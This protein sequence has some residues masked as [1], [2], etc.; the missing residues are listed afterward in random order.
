MNGSKSMQSTHHPYQT[1]FSLSRRSSL[2]NIKIMNHRTPQFGV[3]W[4]L[5]FGVPPKCLVYFL[6]SVTWWAKKIIEHERA[7]E[8]TDKLVLLP[9]KWFHLTRYNHTIWG[10]TWRARRCADKPN[11]LLV[12]PAKNPQGFLHDL[13]I[14]GQF[15]PKLSQFSLAWRGLNL[16]PYPPKKF[17]K[18]FACQKVI[19][20]PYS[21]YSISRMDEW[22]RS[23]IIKS[24]FGEI[25]KEAQT[26]LQLSNSVCALV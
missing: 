8:T 7:K 24:C 22:K 3:S 5:N 13:P 17:V 6:Q 14:L 19:A 18:W 23:E 26:S 2:F 20:F 25:W 10:V 1:F 12:E 21:S 15:L 4:R 9:K 16:L 11:Y